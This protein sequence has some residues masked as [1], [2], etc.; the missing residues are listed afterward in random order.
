M[1]PKMDSGCVQPGEEFEMLYDVSRPLTPE[2]V[3][4]IMDQLM[5]HEASNLQSARTSG[6]LTIA[7][8]LAPGLSLVANHI[9]QRIC[10]S[11]LDARAR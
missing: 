8:V 9:H 2:D 7:D 6:V 4:G 1:D 10:G 11:P 5:C 3:L